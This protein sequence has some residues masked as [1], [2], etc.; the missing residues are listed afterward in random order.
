MSLEEVML[1]EARRGLSRQEASLDGL[2][3][4]TTAVLSVSAIV[5]SL[6]GETR[7][8]RL[9]SWGW[10]ALTSFLVSTGLAVYVLL[11][12]PMVFGLKVAQWMAAID[13]DKANP[14]AATWK[15]AKELGTMRVSNEA[16]IRRWVFTYTGT[17]G[18]LAA[19]VTLWV[20]SGLS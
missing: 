13:R 16:Q 19:Q 17:C 3:T 15:V 8:T 20:F 10:L 5:F 18:L 12:R 4:R 2:R 14:E 9:D 7:A 11:P 1:D 6:L